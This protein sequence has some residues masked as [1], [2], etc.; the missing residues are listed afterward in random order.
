ML[1]S[2]RLDGRHRAVSAL[3]AR[4]V[5]GDDRTKQ[6]FKDECDINVLVKRFAKTGVI[7][8][9][10]TVPLRGDF[11]DVMDFRGMQDALNAARASFMSLSSDVR[12]RFGH[13]PE[14]FIKWTLDKENLPELRKLGLAKPEVVPPPK[15]EPMEVRVVGEVPVSGDKGISKRDS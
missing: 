4:K 7:M 9:R 14:K 8:Q 13:N 12:E 11:T 6:S 10:T 5:V 2:A 3:V 15:P 1:R